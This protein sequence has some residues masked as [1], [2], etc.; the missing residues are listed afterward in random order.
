MKNKTRVR[1]K[2]K[3]LEPVYQNMAINSLSSL[4]AGFFRNKEDVGPINADG[5]VAISIGDTLY[6]VDV[7]HISM[8]SARVHQFL[9]FIIREYTHRVRQA[10][11][12][13]YI[14]ENL[15][16]TFSFTDIAESFGVTTEGAKPLAVSAA[17]VLQHLTITAFWRKGR[18]NCYENCNVL[19]SY[20]VEIDNVTRRGT[21][22]VMLGESFAVYLSYM[23]VLWY[24]STL[25]RV[26]PK[27]YPSAY[28]F[29]Y[30]LVL[31]V[32]LNCGDGNQ[33]RISV[34]SLLQATAEIPK[35]IFLDSRYK[36][37]KKRIITPF[38]RDM[39]ALIKYGTLNNWHFEINGQP[40]SVNERDTINHDLFLKAIVV[41]TLSDN[42]EKK[43]HKQ[44]VRKAEKKDTG[45][46]K[47]LKTT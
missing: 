46:Y 28:V 29:G 23:P 6:Y 4:S 7:S 37:V 45:H 16:Y 11:S 32:K 31:N 12:I 40:I 1:G 3:K 5:K 17:T 18:S 10:S 42:P 19:Q 38:I 22:S 9:M 24:P 43:Y 26:S 39:D 27:K 41:Y 36:Q 20:K 44:K 15:V 35:K 25:F 21:I 30:K 33:N 13:L 14:K 34:N 8:L 47:S 2:E